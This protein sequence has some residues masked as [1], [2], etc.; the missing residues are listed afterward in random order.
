MDE[1]ILLYSFLSVGILALLFGV[2][3]KHYLKYKI[4]ILYSTYI[5]VFSYIITRLVYYY[6]GL[7]ILVRYDEIKNKYWA[8]FTNG[9]FIKEAEIFY[10][11]LV[12]I[13]INT[14]VINAEK[15]NWTVIIMWLSSIFINQMISYVL[16]SSIEKDYDVYVVPYQVGVIAYAITSATYVLLKIVLFTGLNVKQLIY[17]KYI[18]VTIVLVILFIVNIIISIKTDYGINALNVNL[19]YLTGVI[20]TFLEMC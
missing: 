18:M 4:N 8:F 15:D 7:N 19:G 20:F 17:N 6:S 9:L 11:L 1:V 12:G 13:W 16:F 5:I 2:Y 10:N 3:V 14:A